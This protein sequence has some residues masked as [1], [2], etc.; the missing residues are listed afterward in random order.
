[1]KSTHT[2]LPFVV[3]ATVALLVGCSTTSTPASPGTSGV[4]TSSAPGT[5][6]K[7]TG[8]TAATSSGATISVGSGAV[9]VPAID[10]GTVDLTKLPLGDNK[11]STAPT[12]GSVYQCASGGGGGPAAPAGAPAFPWVNTTAKTWDLTTK[13][14][15]EGAVKWP[16]ATFTDTVTGD[17]R[18]ITGNDLPVNDT[19][20]VYPAAASDP[21]SAKE[22]RPSPDTVA[23]HTY[24]LTLPA[25]PTAAATPVCVGG[26]VGIAMN[27]VHIYNAFDANNNDAAAQEVQDDCSGHPN[28]QGYHY[29]SLPLCFLTSDTTTGHSPQFGYAFDGYPIFGPRGENGKVLT[30]ADLDPCHGITDT[31]TWNGQQVSMYHYVANWEFPYIVGCYYGTP[32]YGSTGTP[33]P[34]GNG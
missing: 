5:T 2:I 27:G 7:A 14:M 26:E 1:M 18:V 11:T 9:Q 6:A 22:Y 24:T 21:A 32:K 29:H 13:I 3:G 25:N 15:T 20:G 19:T 4:T 30:N 12:S 28:T 10:V 8:T 34:F 17:N 16:N 23:P 31:V 33:Q